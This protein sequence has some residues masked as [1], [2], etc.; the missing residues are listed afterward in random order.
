[1]VN[2]NNSINSIGH[3]GINQNKIRPSETNFPGLSGQKT[4]TKTDKN[5][6]K[7]LDNQTNTVTKKAEQP[8]SDISTYSPLMLRYGVNRI[9][10]IKDIAVNSGI[11]DL[12]NEDF[13]YAIRYG[14]SLLADYLV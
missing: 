10:E 3:L 11:D 2:I 1:M 7:V 13:D 9:N 8:K 4:N 12:T 14:K 6:S 5:F